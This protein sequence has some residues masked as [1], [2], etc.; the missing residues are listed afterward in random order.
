[1]KLRIPTLVSLPLI[2]AC[3]TEGAPPDVDLDDLAR[4]RCRGGFDCNDGNACTTDACVGGA[5][6]FTAVTAPTPRGLP[7][8]R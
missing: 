1:M 3:L 8:R 6:V 5:C 2:A 7:R 4:K